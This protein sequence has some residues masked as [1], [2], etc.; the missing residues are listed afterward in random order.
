MKGLELSEKY[1]NAFGK[2]MIEKN[3]PSLKGR[4]AV[5]L[6]GQ[7]SECLGFDDNISKDHDYGPSFCLWLTREDYQVY[8][9][10]LA[11]ESRK[12]P[13]DIERVKGRLEADG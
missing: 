2:E 9:K 1:Y 6:V 3:F 13:K 8:G 7:G 12:L 10:A 5:G 11:E 4:V